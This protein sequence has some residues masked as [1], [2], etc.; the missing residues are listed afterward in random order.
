MLVFSKTRA[1]H[2]KHIDEV[3]RRL[4]EASL[5]IDINKSEFY[6]TKTRYL[7]V[8]ISTTGMSIDTEKVQAIMTWKSP[9]SIKEL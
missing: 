7:S 9:S 6:T 3:I 8:I 5:Q 1:E 4:G 2:A